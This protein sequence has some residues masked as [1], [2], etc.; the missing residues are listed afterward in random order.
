MLEGLYKVSPKDNKRVR[1]EQLENVNDE[2]L[3][4]IASRFKIEFDNNSETLVTNLALK[5]QEALNKNQIDVALEICEVLYDL[6]KKWKDDFTKVKTLLLNAQIA[7]YQGESQIHFLESALALAKKIKIIDIEVGIRVQ[8]AFEYYKRRYY[9]KVLKEIKKIEKYPDFFSDN[10]T[11]IL[12]LQSR[13]YWETDEFIKGFD[14]TLKWFDNLKNSLKDVHS[15][16]LVIV[17][18]LT[19]MNSL[20]LPYSKEKITATKNDIS[21][22]LTHLGTATHIFPEILRNIDVLFAKSLMLVEPEILYQFADLLLQTSRWNDEEKY[23][24]LCQKLS[25]AFYN[26]NDFEKSKTLMLNAQ[27]YAKDKKYTKIEPLIKY[28]M[29]EISSLIF[30][31]M[32]FDPLFDPFSAESVKI[33]TDDLKEQSFLQ[34]ISP[35]ANNFPATSYSQF[36]RII[37]KASYSFIYEKALKIEGFSAEDERSFFVLDLEIAEEKIMLLMKEDFK[38]DTTEYH[39]L[40]ST[41]TPYYS[42]IGLLTDKRKPTMNKLDDIEEVLLKVQRAINCPASKAI[43]YLPEINPQLNLFRFYL[44]EGGFRDL[45]VKILDSVI[46][47]KGKYEFLKIPDILQIF[48]ADP[49]TIFDLSLRDIDKL[50]SLANLINHAYG[51]QIS[52][53]TLLSFF[54]DLIEDFLKRS[55]TR[56]WKDFY[57]QYS[58]L[59]TKGTFLSLSNEFMDKKEALCEKLVLIANKLGEE[60]KILETLYHRTFLGLI[61]KND[62]FN[63]DLL[64]LK[65]QAREYQNTKFILVSD[66]LQLI[67]AKELDKQENTIQTLNLFCELCEFK[68]WDIL[69]EMFI[70]LLSELKEIKP[71]FEMCK[72]REVKDSGIYLYLHL[73]K[74]L[75]KIQRYDSSVELLQWVLNTMKLRKDKFHFSEHIWDFMFVTANVYMHSLSETVPNE[76]LEKFE[77]NKNEIIQNLLD[78]TEWITDPL[79]LVDLLNDH[80]NELLDQTDFAQAEKFYHW[81]EQLMFYYWDIFT[82]EKN[83]EL[84]NEVNEIKKRIES[85]HFI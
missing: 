51:V 76:L 22:L 52:P 80:I 36:L 20:E 50:N 2:Y 8:L 65:A 1:K 19:V 70:Y 5:G 68:D 14:S 28:K 9:K 75:I 62:D 48:Q 54:H 72:E 41:L 84:L 81:I 33:N 38:V 45:K 6:S 77:V 43:I 58:W 46:R 7:N 47:L 11:I 27:K 82:S 4:Q 66:I 61:S 67:N 69:L 17:Y 24:F 83:K 39:S 73:A 85:Q 25:D 40:H 30:Y 34:I 26:I 44:Q 15:L 12:E 29:T 37:D 21:N 74:H 53:E 78:K 64:N 79:F 16:F 42:V 10:A 31:F 63:N 32:S 3:S 55:D 23:L 49:I 71:L 60:E 35:M 56:F 13:T 59:Q 18:L 57:F